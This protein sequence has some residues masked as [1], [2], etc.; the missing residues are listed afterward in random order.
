MRFCWT[1]RRAACSSL[2]SALP[3][4]HPSSQ[5]ARIDW[6]TDWL[7]G[8][9]PKPGR[10]VKCLIFGIKTQRLPCQWM[11]V[12][13]RMNLSE[14]QRQRSVIRTLNVVMDIIK[15]GEVCKSSAI[16]FFLLS[17]IYSLPPIQYSVSLELDLIAGDERKR[18]RRRRTSTWSKRIL[19]HIAGRVGGTMAAW[20]DGIWWDEVRNSDFHKFLLPAGEDEEE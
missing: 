8:S 15:L 6:L 4:T 17:R 12:W 13:G 7:T 20:G 18:S 3:I 9:I 11:E 19:C 5:P 16:R 2:F 14:A 10:G 1:K